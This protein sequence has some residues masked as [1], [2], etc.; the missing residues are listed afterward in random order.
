M[1]ASGVDDWSDFIQHTPLLNAK[2]ETEAR[3]QVEYIA[4]AGVGV[5]EQNVIVDTVDM[6][7]CRWAVIVL[8]NVDAP[9]SRPDSHEPRS[10]EM[11]KVEHVFVLLHQALDGNVDVVGHLAKFCP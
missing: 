4:I 10:A 3:L 1:F 6:C 8:S 5:E 7:W 9:N 2:T 11:V